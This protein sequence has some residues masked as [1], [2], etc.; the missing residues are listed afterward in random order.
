M[1]NL[2]NDVLQKETALELAKAALAS[3]TSGMRE[4]DRKLQLGSITSLQHLQEE[5]AYLGAEVDLAA[6][7]MDLQQSIETY[8]W[9]LRGYME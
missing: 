4:A 9:A 6:A 1:R 2:Y 7:N 5:A 8:E 3:E